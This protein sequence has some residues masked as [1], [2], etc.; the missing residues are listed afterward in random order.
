MVG[1]IA[2]RKVYILVF[3]SLICLTLLTTGMAFV[4]LGEGWNTLIALL[5]A[6]GK[7]S[8]VALFF[9]H[10]RWSSHLMR[11]VVLA[12]V[13]WLSILIVLTMSDVQTRNWT[14]VP[15]AWE[16]SAPTSSEQPPALAR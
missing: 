9:M 14:P 8:L 10:L 16:S 4:N 6:I 1:H 7:A 13:L 15:T 5:I 12:A 11:I 2:P 3:A